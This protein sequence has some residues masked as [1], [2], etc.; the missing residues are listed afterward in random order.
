MTMKIIQ[1]YI[2]KHVMIS[3][4]LVFIVV[5]ILSFMIN[6]LGELRDIGTGEYGFGQAILHVLLMQP[7]TLYQLFPMLILLGGVLGLGMLASSHELIV[8]RTAGLS[9]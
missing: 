3:T 7:R 5:L 6:L 8:M 2:A 9:V 4:G 1:R